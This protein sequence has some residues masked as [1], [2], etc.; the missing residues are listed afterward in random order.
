MAVDKDSSAV[1]VT[2]EKFTQRAEEKKE[3][4]N[5]I[6]PLQEWLRDDEKSLVKAAAYLKGYWGPEKYE[7]IGNVNDLM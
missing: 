2:F 3:N 6:A 1:P 4:E 5:F 7:R